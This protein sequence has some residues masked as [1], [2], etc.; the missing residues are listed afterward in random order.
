MNT[1]KEPKKAC[2]IA[3]AKRKKKTDVKIKAVD[4]Y[5]S[6]HFKLSLEYARKR[7]TDDRI[8]ILSDKYGLVKLDREIGTYNMS[9]K[10]ME[11]TERL[12]WGAKVI[13]QLRQEGYNLDTDEF[14]ILAGAMYVRYITGD[15]KIQN[16]HLPL[17]GKRQGEQLHF[18]KS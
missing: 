1:I 11:H 8:Y 4:L 2:L 17:K 16:P 12:A 3:C 7:F 18:L 5:I 9:L 14:E 15:G 13:D 6:V 10:E